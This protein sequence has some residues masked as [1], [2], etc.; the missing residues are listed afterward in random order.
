[1]DLILYSLYLLQI[2]VMGGGFWVAAKQL[3]KIKNAMTSDSVRDTVN[4]FN[5]IDREIMTDPAL[6]MIFEEDST[7]LLKK[8]SDE[9]DQEALRIKLI[10]F[11]YIVLNQLEV[12]Y[13]MHRIKLLDEQIWG[14]YVRWVKAK[15]TTNSNMGKYLIATRRT[16]ARYFSKDFSKFI[17]VEV[18]KCDQEEFF[19]DWTK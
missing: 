1:M 18:L 16:T 15:I 17:W 13:T 5:L 14:S 6:N 9:P 8:V 7:D 4:C 19:N 10:N 11:M 12:V 2:I 3:K